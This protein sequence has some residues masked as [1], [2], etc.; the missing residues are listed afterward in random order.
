MG[1]QT[2]LT[3]NHMTGIIMPPDVTRVPRINSTG[4]FRAIYQPLVLSSL[5]ADQPFSFISSFAA[6]HFHV[7]ALSTSSLYR[8]ASPQDARSFLEGPADGCVV[9]AWLHRNQTGS[10]FSN[11]IGRRLKR[12]DPL[13][14][15]SSLTLNPPVPTEKHRCPSFR[16]P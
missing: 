16:D 14:L 12:P 4:H 9:D 1:P 11:R 7:A 15:E 5:S 2:G 13:G 3:K 8:R 6:C 10:Q